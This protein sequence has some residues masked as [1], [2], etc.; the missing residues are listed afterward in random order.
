MSVVTPIMRKTTKVSDL[1]FHFEKFRNSRDE[2]ITPLEL[3]YSP[4]CRI[5]DN[6]VIGEEAPI[7][8]ERIGIGE[9]LFEKLSDSPDFVGQVV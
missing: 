6:V 7:Y 9:L 8:T 4:P 5:V 2:F 1:K 3:Q